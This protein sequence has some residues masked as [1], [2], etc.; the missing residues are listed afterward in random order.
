LN[1]TGT[2]TSADI[3]VAVNYVFKGGPDP[4]PCPAS[5][6][7]NCGG[8]VTSADIIILVNYV[9]K[10]GPAPCDACTSPLAAGC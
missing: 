2:I 8:T 3:I 1:L 10:G 4:Q 7:V 9:F 5:A 6:D